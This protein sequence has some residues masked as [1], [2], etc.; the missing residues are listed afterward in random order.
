MAT[1]SLMLCMSLFK[2]IPHF[3][4]LPTKWPVF[5]SDMQT[6]CTQRGF[7]RRVVIVKTLDPALSEAWTR[8]TLEPYGS[9][10]LLGVLTAAVR[11]TCVCL[12][13]PE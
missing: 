4:F 12:H 3:A 6:Q 5:V 1:S 7:Q 11:Q 10:S 2:L 8:N 13:P 9:R